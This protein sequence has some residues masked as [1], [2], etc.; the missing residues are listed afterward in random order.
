M[1]PI[2]DF[3][4]PWE[5]VDVYWWGYVLQFF[6]LLYSFIGLSI[7]C[8]DH[9]VPA[10]ET[11]CHR[12][13]IG[14][15]V[16]GA[17]FMA[18]GSA[19][20]EMII[21]VVATIQNAT[22]PDGGDP[23]A[24]SLGV[25]AI[26]GS[27]MIAFSLIPAACGLFAP[28]ELSLKRRPLFRDEFFYLSSMAIL[29]YIM[30]DNVVHSWEAGLLVFNYCIYLM[31]IV[32]AS[33]F[34][35]YYNESYLGLPMVSSQIDLDPIMDSESV[36]SVHK[37]EPATRCE[38]AWRD[39]LHQMS[40]ADFIPA[41]EEHDWDVPSLWEGITIQDFKDMGIVQRGRIAKFRAMLQS[42]KFRQLLDDDASHRK[43]SIFTQDEHEENE[44]S[45]MRAFE[46][47][48]APCNFLFEHT[49]VDC[50]VGSPGEGYYLF[51][52]FVALFWVSC[53][54]FLLSSVVQRWVTLSG[55]P[56]VFFGLILVSMG[57]EIPDTI[58]SVSI[59]KKGYGSMAVANCQGTQVINIC[60]GL[61]MPWLLT[62]IG[63]AK[64]DVNE[65]L[66]IP[67]IFTV[68]LI[69]V[70]M[71]LLL[72]HAICCG[73]NKAVLNR[74]KSYILIATYFAAIGGFGIYL[75]LEGEL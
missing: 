59:S 55:V 65:H 61:G 47:M 4:I 24:T 19:A 7:V 43:L 14:D 32:F 73:L 60:L 48:A 58:A 2:L 27:G 54:S 25:S 29:V 68:C 44:S 20:P 39:R 38:I 9:M 23:E 71:S 37:R 28:G 33:G 53:F 30:Y 17:T 8:D 57:A 12:W 70:N 35:R 62:S 41:F 51:T 16:A 49:C 46:F 66:V 6:G 74:T 67:A 21:N 22:S 36:A 42:K 52:F 10:L 75:H 5:E 18:F 26:I 40:F 3:D 13:K 50:E 72:G 56:M 63:G 45:L 1:L 11:L 69:A 34:R 64:N 31:V 15:D